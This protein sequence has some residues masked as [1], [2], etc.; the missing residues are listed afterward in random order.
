M[1]PDWAKYFHT[2]TSASRNFGRQ[3]DQNSDTQQ[4][5]EKTRLLVHSMA[6]NNGHTVTKYALEYVPK[7]LDYGKKYPPHK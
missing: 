4:K 1:I 2:I 7:I 5:I 3:N 6:T